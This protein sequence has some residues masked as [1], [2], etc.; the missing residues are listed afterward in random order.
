MPVHHP[1]AVTNRALHMNL[2][3]LPTTLDAAAR[4]STTFAVSLSAGTVVHAN[5]ITV[6]VTPDGTWAVGVTV[7]PSSAGL[8]GVF[9]PTTRTPTGGTATAQTFTFTPPSAGSGTIT[10]TAT[11]LTNSSSA[12]ALTAS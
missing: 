10:A 9:S 5:P 2:R 12:R 3:A 4:P 1:F 11:G 8:S 6:T 7:T